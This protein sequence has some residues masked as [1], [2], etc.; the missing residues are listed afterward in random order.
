MN[1][2][3]VIGL[4]CSLVVLVFVS[5]GYGFWYSLLSEKSAEVSSITEKIT[6]QNNATTQIEQAKAELSQLSSQEATVDQYFV[7]TNDVVPFLEQ[8]QSIGTFLGAK[9]EVVSVSAVSGNP[10]GQLNLSL[11]I[12]GPFDAVARTLG[13][14]EYGPYDS[15][16]TSLSLSTSATPGDTPS[17]SAAV[18]NAAATFTVG[19]QTGNTQSASSQPVAS[20]HAP[21]TPAAT[22]TTQKISPTVTQESISAS[23]TPDASSS[24]MTAE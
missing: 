7:A 17:T 6:E 20:S 10:Y 2:G 8:I 15:S 23:T 24:K 16:I 22:S 12:S 1:R 5:V 13:S 3:P 14:I 19:A 9:V 18:W 11:S 21:T 4:I